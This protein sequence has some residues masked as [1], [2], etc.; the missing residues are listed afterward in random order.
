MGV[1]IIGLPFIR[2]RINQVAD[3]SL[4]A[5]HNLYAGRTAE[6]NLVERQSEKILPRRIRDDQPEG[7]IAVTNRADFQTP[8]TSRKSKT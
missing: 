5:S 6:T 4:H 7:S 2:Q 8:A 3:Q 1:R